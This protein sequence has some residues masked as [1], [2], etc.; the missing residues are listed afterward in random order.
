MEASPGYEGLFEDV[1]L[2]M[3]PGSECVHAC[4]GVLEREK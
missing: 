3:G 4:A 2:L 1:R